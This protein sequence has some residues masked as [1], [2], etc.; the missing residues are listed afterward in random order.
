MTDFRDMQESL[1]DVI[2]GRILPE[3]RERFDAARRAMEEPKVTPS[4][5]MDFAATR[6][7]LE[8]M[9]AV[10]SDALAKV[11]EPDPLNKGETED[12]R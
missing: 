8:R 11:P 10:V 2:R 5:T 6:D 7:A 9:K 4:G 12:D 1:L 3:D